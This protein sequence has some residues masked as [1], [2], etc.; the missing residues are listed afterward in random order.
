MLPAIL[1]GLMAG[2][3]L[4]AP[5]PSSLDS[6]LVFTGDPYFPSA[7]APGSSPAIAQFEIRYRLSQEVRLGGGVRIYLGYPWLG[8]N[9]NRL[10]QHSWNNFQ[11]EAPSDFDYARVSIP[12]YSD[13]ELVQG[14]GVTRPDTQFGFEVRPTRADRPLTQGQ[15]ITFL[16]GDPSSGCPGYRMPK[17]SGG[18]WI[19]VEESADAQQQHRLMLPLAHYPHIEVGPDSTDRFEVLVDSNGAPGD[20]FDVTIQA[21]QNEDGFDTN[22]AIDRTFTGSVLLTSG[23]LIGDLPTRVSFGSKDR[24]VKRVRLHPDVLGVDRIEAVL[25]SDPQVRGESNPFLVRHHIAGSP[26]RRLLWGNLHVHSAVGGHGLG[27]PEQAFSYARDDA[28]LDFIALTEH[29]SG[30]NDNQFNWF[31]LRGF[32][33][34][35][36]VA[37]EFVAFVGYEWT[38]RSAGHRNVVFKNAAAEDEYFCRTYWATG[39]ELLDWMVGRNVIGVPHHPAWQSSGPMDWGQALAHANQPLVEIYS[40]HGS[41]EYHGNPLP[42]HRDPAETHPPGLGVYVQEALRNGRKLG[43]S[44]DSDTHLVNPGSN[45]AL[46]KRYSRLGL[47]GVYAGEFSRDGIWAG[48]MNRRTLATTGARILGAFLIETQGIGADFSLNRDPEFHLEV[49]GTAPIAEMTLY[50]NG[51]DPV[52]HL[53]PQQRD[54]ALTWTDPNT[55]PGQRYSYYLKVIQEDGHRAWISPIWLDRL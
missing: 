49:F 15:E 16:L 48:M 50:R 28:A 23:Q 52:L 10:R 18:I 20:V 19:L 14:D 24:G 2:L 54:V 27:M 5:S 42:I 46:P 38:S 21:R 6:P 11:L 9:Q 47:T 22:S 44:G 33:D 55:T 29:C 3:Q 40:W 45:I 7:E 4:P 26:Y 31:A 1:L 37:D 35:E 43:F 51:D 41:S 39:Q 25:E 34:T 12:G 53:T 36:S 30:V 17:H 13:Y 32:S 8:Q